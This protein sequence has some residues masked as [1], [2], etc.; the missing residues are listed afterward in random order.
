MKSQLL[1]VAA[2]TG[3]PCLAAAQ[4]F[5]AA[6]LPFK[7][8]SDSYVTGGLLIDSKPRYLGAS[9]A[10][11]RALPVADWEHPSGWFAGTTIGIGYN[12]SSRQGLGY[13]LRVSPDWGRKERRHKSL[14]G[15]G[16]I[17]AQAVMGAF[18]SYLPFDSLHLQASSSHGAGSN[19]DG[20]TLQLGARYIKPL[21]QDFRIGVGLGAMWMNREYAQ[22]YFGVTAAQSQASGLASFELNE[23]GRVAVASAE[24]SYRVMNKWQLTVQLERQQLLGILKRSPLAMDSASDTVRVLVLRAW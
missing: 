10:Q 22:S 13:G 6:L 14:R 24:L 17:P 1:L 23:G 11:V 9:E 4:G 18:V 16:D 19:R 2:L 8:P 12:F 21:A 5:D 20:A 3:I 7:R 15:L